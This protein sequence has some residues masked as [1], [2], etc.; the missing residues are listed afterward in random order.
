MSTEFYVG[1]EGVT[2]NV[3]NKDDILEA[4]DQMH[5]Q[6]IQNIGIGSDEVDILNQFIDELHERFDFEDD[7]DDES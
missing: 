1:Q 5:S 6:A 2:V 7:D 3:E 4:I